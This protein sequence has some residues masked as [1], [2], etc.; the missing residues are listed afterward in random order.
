MKRAIFLM[1]LGL[2]GISAP[3][4]AADNAGDALTIEEFLQKLSTVPDVVSRKDPFV[5]PVAP[6]QVVQSGSGTVEGPGLSDAPVLERYPVTQYGIVATLLGDQYPRA[7]VRLPDA[8]RGQV[9]I[10]KLKDKLG[11][12]GGVISKILKDGVVVLQSQR[13]P[14]G[15][16]EKTEVVLGVGGKGAGNAARRGAAPGAPATDAPAAAPAKTEEVPGEK[17]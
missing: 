14:L 2:A 16:I 9:L 3:V 13:S 8:E 5:Q 17:K 12:N 10:V 11:Q 7:L 4:L 6:Y 1:C 15:F